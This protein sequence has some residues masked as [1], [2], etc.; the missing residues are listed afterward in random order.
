MVLHKFKK[1]NGEEVESYIDEDL[2]KNLDEVKDS[3]IN[4]GWDYV[5]VCSGIVGVG[6][7][8][9]AQMICKYLDPSF[10]VKDR[11]CF[12][13]TGKDGLIERTTNGK[14]GEAYMLD[15]SFE[16]LNTQVTRSTEF[17]K[18]INHLQLIRQRGLFIILCLP[19]FFDLSKSVAIFRTSHLFVVYHKSFQ[20]GRFAG[21][22]R[23]EKRQLYIKGHK[24]VDYNCVEPNIRGR[25]VKTWIADLELYEKLKYNHLREQADLKEA[26]ITNK[27]TLSR[28]ALI[29]FLTKEKYRVAEIAKIAM[30]TRQQIYNIK[31]K[32][33]VRQKE[34]ESMR[35]MQEK[36]NK[37]VI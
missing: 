33:E 14:K 12:R 36:S 5:A 24:F 4:K 27:D 37:N 2:S 18:L 6:K 7:S 25:F 17:V 8:T 29:Y 15:E 26:G 10:N 3:V 22:G 28:N 23:E 11:V 21:F 30:M 13:A 34:N 32:E 19:N 20:R 16:S 1:D 9:M 31:K 35:N